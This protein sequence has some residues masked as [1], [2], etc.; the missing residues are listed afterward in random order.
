MKLKIYLVKNFILNISNLNKI[1]EE[2][3]NKA[4][5]MLIIIFPAM[6]LNVKAKIG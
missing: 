1:I 2:I 4:K 5:L 6:K 3:I